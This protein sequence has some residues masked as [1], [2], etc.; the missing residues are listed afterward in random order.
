MGI[1]TIKNAIENIENSCI[2]TLNTLYPMGV[3]DEI[4]KRYWDEITFLKKSKYVDDFEIFR[5]LSDE[6]RKSTNLMQVRGTITGSFLVYLLS[7]GGYNPLPGHYYCKECGYYER[8]DTNQMGIDLPP[9]NCPKCRTLLYADGFNLPIESVWGTNGS[10]IISTECNITAEFFPYAKRVLQ[11]IYP[12]NEIVPW[13][14]FEMPDI[15]N[16][17][18]QARP[19]IGISQMGYVIIPTGNT[20]TDY[21]HLLSYLDNGEA[22]LTGGGW[23]LEE[24]FLKPIRL[25]PLHTMEY[26]LKLQK[27][28]GI[29]ANELS[30]KELREITWS[31][32]YNSTIL[33]QVT[34]SRFHEYHPKTFK[35]MMNLMAYGHNTYIWTTDELDSTCEFN[36]ASKF[37]QMINSELFKKYP[38]FTR[39]DFFEYML[40]E[41]IDR[42]LAFE[43]SEQ[44]RKGRGA[45]TGKFSDEYF[46]LPIPDEI[47]E[48]SKQYRYVFPRAH[49]VE[50]MLGYMKL[51]YY[52]K[53]DGRAYSKIVFKK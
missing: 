37:K 46:S 13:G 49:C 16:A 36:N 4:Y 28:T 18:V 7:N 11:T 25:F 50:Y 40:S 34:S 29:Y 14:M 35:D 31:N 47:K 51:A 5:R 30:V 8:V 21:D 3:P 2:R 45:A 43:A 39:E 6:T 20:I 48:L 9:K 1:P 22:C 15:G 53:I 41:G 26:L 44:I 27:A 10:K 32:L 24:S 12:K 52:A 17:P 19:V 23:E 38:C 33:D 42:A